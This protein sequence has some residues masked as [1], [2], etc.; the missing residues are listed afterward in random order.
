MHIDWLHY[1]PCTALAGGALIGA[2]AAILVL[3]NRCIAG[4]SGIAGGLMT[5]VGTR[6]GAGCTSGDGV[7]GWSRLSPRWWPACCCSK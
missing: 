6:C 5:G 3:F 7:R 1:T 2:A 4:I